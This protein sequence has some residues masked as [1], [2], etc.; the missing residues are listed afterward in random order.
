MTIAAFFDG[1]HLSMRDYDETLRHGGSAVWEQPARSSHLCFERDGGFVVVDVWESAE[2]LMAFGETVI[3]PAMA[4]A[5]IEPLQPEVHELRNRHQG[6]STSNV[7]TVAAIYEAFGRGDIPAILDRLADDVDWEAGRTEDHGVPWLRPGTGKAHVA[8]FFETLAPLEFKRF[9]PTSIIGDGDTVLAVI[10][11]EAHA[12]ATGATID[13]LEVHVWT[14]DPDGS[15]R[16]LRHVVD[17]V[18]HSKA[19]GAR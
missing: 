2:D 15:V 12:P 17:T 3:G 8:S 11:L 18:Q 19:A 10:E 4:A 1:S 7:A 9:E 16:S 13:D 6:P 5:G 14:F